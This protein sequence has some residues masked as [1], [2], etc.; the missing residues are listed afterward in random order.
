MKAIQL[1]FDRLMNFLSQGV[2]NMR[3]KDLSGPK[4]FL[5]RQLRIYLLA[6]KGFYEDRC[7]LRA[8]ALTFYSLLSVVPILA[9]AFGVAK[10]FGLDKLLEKELKSNLSGQ[11]EVLEWLIDFANRM[12]ENTKGT[13][14]AGFGLVILF[15]SVMKVLGNIEMSFNDVWQIKKGRSWGRKFTDYLAIMILLLF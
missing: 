4:Y 11:Q 9:M 12:L 15:W 10:G 13:L 7:Q 14:V 8:S 3:L 5:I 6:V 2:W 1:Y